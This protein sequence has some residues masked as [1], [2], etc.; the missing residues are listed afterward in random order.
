M[1]RFTSLSS[2]LLPILAFAVVAWTQTDSSGAAIASD[3]YATASPSS[4]PHTTGTN[5]TSSVSI[6]TASD[7]APQLFPAP[8]SSSSAASSA[9]STNYTNDDPTDN[10][11]GLVNYYFVFLAILVALFL[12]GAWLYY[13]RRKSAAFRQRHSRQDALARD[14]DGWP[15]PDQGRRRWIHGNW[16]TGDDELSRR[17]E[18]LNEA[19]EA[20]PPYK[21]RTSSERTRESTETSEEGPAIP[22]RTMTREGTTLKPPDYSETVVQPLPDPG[23]PSS[24][25]EARRPDL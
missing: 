15:G 2:P 4:T 10:D 23:R 16:R 19:G 7:L 18:G 8:D 1:A 24:S 13:K 9:A 12:V 6:P 17:E 3:I 25:S 5:T 21:A 20:P 14:L 22:L 11:G